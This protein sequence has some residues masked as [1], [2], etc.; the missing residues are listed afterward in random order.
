MKMRQY[1]VG[2]AFVQSVTDLAGFRALDAAWS[3]PEQLPM[4]AELHAPQTWLQRV[5]SVAVG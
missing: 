2:E 4:L 1:E 5:G 3:A